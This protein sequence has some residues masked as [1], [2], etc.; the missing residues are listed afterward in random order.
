MTGFADPAL[1]ARRP[2]GSVVLQKPF[3]IDDLVAAI[4]NA[5]DAPPP[6]PQVVDGAA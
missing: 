2:V 3:G 4:R 1:A 6:E 5:L